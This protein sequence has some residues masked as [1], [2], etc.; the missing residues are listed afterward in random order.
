MLV[1][2]LGRVDDQSAM[3][4]IALIAIALSMV[5][6]S[7]QAQR[8]AD[9]R[10]AA[11]ETGTAAAQFLASVPSARDGSPT[12][13]LVIGGVAG[14]VSAGAILW[15]GIEHCVEYDCLAPVLLAT[16]WEGAAIPLGV[17][18]ANRRRGRMAVLPSYLIE[19]LGL[20]VGIVAS[21][22]RSDALVAAVAVLA[23][24]AQIAVAVNNERRSATVPLRE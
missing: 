24:A 22:V 20:T 5:A 9:S 12:V 23:P 1:P 21:E 8:I 19:L 7:A 17:H 16:V 14:A 13:V 15:Y 6:T 4:S 2:Q 3:R 18:L 11:Y 10:T